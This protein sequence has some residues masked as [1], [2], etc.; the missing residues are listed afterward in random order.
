MF[1][2]NASDLQRLSNGE[3]TS[4]F[5]HIHLHI[6]WL[7]NPSPERSAALAVMRMIRTEQT[8]RLFSP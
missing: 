2:V 4:L 1:K 8:R 7:R 3:L 5:N 6:G